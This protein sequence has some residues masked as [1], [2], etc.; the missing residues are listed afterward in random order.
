M[1]RM[2]MDPLVLVSAAHPF[3]DERPPQLMPA[4]PDY[5]QILMERR[6]A[7]LLQAC[8]GAV[9]DRGKILP[10]SGWRSRQEQKQIWADTLAKRGEAYTRSFV[11]LPGCSEHQTGLAIDL[12]CAGQELD[13]ICPCFPE[14]GVYGAFRRAAPDYG[15]I[16]RYP[17]GKEQITG[18]AHEPWHFRY[19]GF[20]HSRI[21]TDRGLV[22]EEY[23][24]MLRR[25]CGKTPLR[26][27]ARRY[28]FEV[29]Y[30]SEGEDAREA[31]RLESRKNS[32]CQHSGDN[33]GGQVWTIWK[34][35][36][37]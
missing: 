2:C 33:R 8:I 22:L 14:N 29:F 25:Y 12:G 28:D 5:P 19:V 27:Q 15:F 1:S 31:A 3:A 37:A 18:I 16:L 20:P 26:F 21:M 11:A 32:C 9:G 35:C 23:L 34:E 17:Q 6:A 13:F 24:E 36:G 7:G 4:D 10:V 30:L